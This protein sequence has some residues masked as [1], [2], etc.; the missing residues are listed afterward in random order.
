MPNG[1]TPEDIIKLKAQLEHIAQIGH[2][3]LVIRVADGRI[4]SWSAQAQWQLREQPKTK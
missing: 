3:E 1:V 2:G 4:I